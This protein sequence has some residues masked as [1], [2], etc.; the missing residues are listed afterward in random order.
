MKD[1]GPKKQIFVD[2]DGV[3]K[4]EEYRPV[5]FNLPQWTKWLTKTVQKKEEPKRLLAHATRR[6]RA[7]GGDV[8]RVACMIG[9]PSPD[10]E[11]ARTGAPDLLQL[12]QLVVFLN[13]MVFVSEMGRHEALYADISD[14]RLYRYKGIGP[15]VRI[16]FPSETVCVTFVRSN[17]RGWY[18][19][20]VYAEVEKLFQDI[21]Q[22]MRADR[23]LRERFPEIDTSKIE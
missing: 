3:T 17:F 6:D 20:I 7:V 18:R 4:V 1:S 23:K 14:V 19:G 11:P 21:R 2:F 10:Y 9:E 12:G 13:R 8:Y 22:K 15:M 16:E 5:V